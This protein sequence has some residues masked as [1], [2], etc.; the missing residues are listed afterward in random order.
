MPRRIELKRTRHPGVYQSG[1]RFVIRWTRQ[2]QGQR[3]DL[4]DELPAGMTLEDA[5][6]ERARRVK[7]SKAPAPPPGPPTVRGYCESWLERKASGMKLSSAEEY[8][9]VIADHILPAPVDAAGKRL[10]GDYRL[11][12]VTRAEVERWVSYAERARR[13]ASRA[14]DAPMVLC[15]RDTLLGW[16]RK[17]VQVLRDAAAEHGLADPTLR[18]KGP[19]AHGRPAVKEQRTLTP[20]ELLSLFDAVAEGWHAEIY[21]AA[22]LGCRPGELYALTWPDVDLERRTITIRK[23][24]Y[25][26]RVGTTKTGKTRVVPIGDELL[27]VLR[28]HRQRLMREQHPA[29]ATGLVFPATEDGRRY[30]DEG[31][32]VEDRG[33]HRGPSSQ[34]NHLKRASRRAGL[35]IEVTPRVLRRTVNTLLVNAG[36]DRLVIRA[37]LGHSSEAM[38]STYYH[39]PNAEKVAAVTTLEQLVRKG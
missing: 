21:T 3:K 34:L 25:K 39:A 19:K 29:L 5:I 11:D 31:R 17:V 2:V 22:A 28:A 26:G 10:L 27:G 14:P 12:E 24:H 23:S 8:A 32:L 36:V 9:R 6:S 37:I 35:P 20:A 38:T 30:D 13:P 15:S 18:V 16:W 33:W 4:S 1:D 7:E